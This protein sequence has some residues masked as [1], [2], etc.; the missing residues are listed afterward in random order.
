MYKPITIGPIKIS[1][2]SKAEFLAEV[3]RRVSS[4]EQTF[5][6][7]PY[8]EFL[9]AALR[10]GEVRDL[11]AKADIAIADGIGIFWAERFLSK[12]L[13]AKSHYG[14]IVEAWLSLIHI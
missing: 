13:A 8:S 9:Y 2:I 3:K 14:K 6:T 5:V 12:P 7:T 11:L 1:A 4:D 10:S